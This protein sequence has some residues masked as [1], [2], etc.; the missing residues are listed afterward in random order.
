MWRYEIGQDKSITNKTLFYEFT[1]FGMDG[2][3]CDIDGDLYIARYGKGVIAILSPQGKLLREVV[4]P[5]VNPT[6]V[7]FGGS[8][9]RTVYVTLQSKK[10]IV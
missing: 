8:D 1:D 5:G 2:M 7:A 4:L 9:F 3:R 10:K 6:N